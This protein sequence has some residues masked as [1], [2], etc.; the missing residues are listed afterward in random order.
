MSGGALVPAVRAEFTKMRSIRSTVV[1]LSVFLLISI[2]I[3][4]LD[5]W[6]A[7]TAID[8]HNA[9]LR[10][11]FSAAQA[12]LDGILYGQLA[13]IVFGVLLVTSEYGTGVVGLSLL[14]MPRRGTAFTAKIAVAALT[15]V[16]VAIPVTLLSYATTELALGPHGVSL[17][18]N[19][20][21]R[22]L[23]GAIGYLA[24]MCV[25]AAGFATVTRSAIVPLAV[26]LPLVLAGSQIL[27]TIGATA[28]VARYL[29]D[30]AGMRMLAVHAGD[31]AKLSPA[32]GFAVLVG[33][34]A[35]AVAAGFLALR[36]RDV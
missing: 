6:S 7:R 28:A 17:L 1:A 24:L 31:S 12:G 8:S 22:A 35:V 18:A 16:V 33:W 30:Q 27:S 9:L 25:L 3:G 20:V 34:T 13:L 15:T 26:L 14:A 11:D 10:P 4:G 21:P 19:G 2:A 32:A 23:I 5:G 36:N 29:P